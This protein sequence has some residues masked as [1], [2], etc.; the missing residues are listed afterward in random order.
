MSDKHT[1]EGS[2]G[3]LSLPWSWVAGIGALLGIGSLGALVVVATVNDAD[4]LSTVALALAVLAFVIQILVFVVQT[5]VGVQQSQQNQAVNADTRALLSELQ[6]RTQDT[7]AV[8]QG[9]YDKLLDRV[10]LVSKETFAEGKDPD[11]ASV[12]RLVDDVRLAI[13]QA[14]EEAI[15]PQ[16]GSAYSSS[17]SAPELR[18]PGL[19]IGRRVNPR[20]STP[21]SEW[22][23][24]ELTR[25]LASGGLADL[26][27]NEIS[28]LNTFAQDYQR[29]MEK[30]IPVGL[31]AIG[32]GD[33]N[34]LLDRGFLYAA[35]TSVGDFFRLTEKG[36]SAARFFLA[37]PPAPDYVL[38]ELPWLRTVREDLR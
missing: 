15:A 21:L 35:S 37:E 10:L 14:R 12:E 31:P 4:T 33:R 19:R 11:T 25:T 29:S 24:R 3:R 20:P 13:I 32:V 36:V 22:P 7:N 27:A 9:Q 18:T 16:P 23:S 2:S 28:T 8:M 30:D 6:T 38:E 5:W 17:W 34:E 26:P 1:L